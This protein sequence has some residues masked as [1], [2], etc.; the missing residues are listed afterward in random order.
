MRVGIDALFTERE[1]DGG[2]DK[3]LFNLLEGFKRIKQDNNIVIFCREGTEEIFRT[4]IPAAQIVPLKVR[5]FT[6]KKSLDMMLLRTFV[7][8]S[9]VSKYKVEILLFAKSYTAFLRYTCP[10]IVIPHDIQAISH[11]RR[12]SF[13][14]AIKEKI[15]LYFDFSLSNHII[16]ISDFDKSEICKYYPGV[17]QKV[18]RIYNPI[19]LKSEPQKT[20]EGSYIVGINISYEHKN[21]LTLI[22]AFERIQEIVPHKLYLIGKIN[23][24]GKMLQQ[25]VKEKKL[26]KKVV[27]TGFISDDAVYDLLA[28]AALY[29]NPSL[30][31]G[32]GMTAVE[33]MLMQ[34][35]TIVSDVTANREVTKGLCKYYQNPCDDQELS[36]IILETLN[37]QDYGQ[38]LDAI[39]RTIEEEY[40]YV[41]IAEKYWELFVDLTGNKKSEKI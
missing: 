7:F 26:E 24:Y 19:Q 31:E 16:A 11:P 12:F 33:A 39:S 17:K 13:W 27:F 9:L 34:V 23:E 41:K 30:F 29:V 2:K 25:Y 14:E 36:E 1:F 28:N 5:L 3:V 10:T 21:V 37:S 40:N 4:I 18:V 6:H 38:Q 35:P 22:K 15:F 20:V 32:F 8:R